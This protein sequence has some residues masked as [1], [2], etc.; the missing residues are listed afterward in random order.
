MLIHLLNLSLKIKNNEEINHLFHQEWAKTT[1][2]FTHYK[3]NKGKYQGDLRESSNVLLNSYRIKWLINIY[4]YAC[5]EYTLF[6]LHRTFCLPGQGRLMKHFTKGR[7]GEG[8]AWSYVPIV[9][10]TFFV[11]VYHGIFFM[12]VLLPFKRINKNDKQKW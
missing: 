2:V 8:G 7:E 9:T 11:I 12:A 6:F 4:I 3:A 1:S 10:Q 5:I